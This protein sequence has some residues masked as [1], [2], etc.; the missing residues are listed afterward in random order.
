MVPVSQSQA[1]RD[2]VFTELKVSNTTT[3]EALKS[4]RLI[5]YIR[6]LW[7]DPFMHVLLRRK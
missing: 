3:Y 2:Y 4:F 7:L 1:L 5:V 6:G